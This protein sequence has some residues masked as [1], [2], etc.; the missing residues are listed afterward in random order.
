MKLNEMFPQASDLEID[1]LMPDS[2]ELCV[3][4]LFF[5]V[6]GLVHDGHDFIDQ[7][8]SNGA[9]AIV[10]S[11][12]LQ[13]KLPG[14]EYV[15]VDEVFP[16]LIRASNVFFDNPSLKMKMIGITGTNGKTTIALTLKRILAKRL[17]SG[18]IGTIGTQ[19]GDL[20]LGPELTTPDII[21]L[22][23]ILY[24]MA[25]ADVKAVA[26]EASSQG[27]ALN[28]TAA[29]HFDLAVFTNLTHD[30]LDYHGTMEN[31]YHAKKKLF[32][33]L[34]DHGIAIIN[35]D[36]EYG[37]RL[38]LEAYPN[39]V[40]Y[41]V[42]KDADYQAKNIVLDKSFSTYTLAYHGQDYPVKT[43]LLAQFNVYNSLAIIACMHEMG[44][45]FSDF[46]DDLIDI[47]PVDGRMEFID[48]GQPFSVIVDYAH[49]PD[50][51]LKLFEYAKT[52]TAPEKRL[53]VVFGCAGKRD[54]TKRAMLGK[55]SGDYCSMIVLTEED[56]RDEKIVDICRE[57]ATGI[58][59]NTPY[60]IIEN[61]SEA[62]AQAIELADSGDT[63]VILGKGNETY[64]YRDYG[65]QYY[66]GDNRVAV[67]VLKQMKAEDSKNDAIE[68]ID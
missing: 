9:I 19:Y 45:E 25:A 39:T 2:R 68:Q 14:I 30:H 46:L 35:R 41:G 26:I 27:L 38:I 50:G 33:G 51:F 3:N 66:L 10:H 23:H 57:I 21:P 64:M 1:A 48:E 47:E 49:T 56:N 17:L 29:V 53:I 62:I 4:S 43:N 67:E 15:Q 63:V 13:T 59:N 31:Y 61:R 16:E 22:Q 8:V 55:L 54:H 5:C 52:I 12:E 32:D 44:Y 58:D 42:G 18:Y 11:R 28:R 6:A 7:A 40:T 65:T 37:R 20:V 60:V 24:D 34:D 36:D